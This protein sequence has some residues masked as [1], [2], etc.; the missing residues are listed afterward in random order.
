MPAVV[1][2]NGFVRRSA[3][4]RD[5]R[6]LNESSIGNSACQS[7]LLRYSLT[8]GNTLFASALIAVG[9]LV[10]S[11]DAVTDLRRR[12]GAVA[13]VALRFPSCTHGDSKDRL[14]G[15]GF[16]SSVPIDNNATV[17]GREHNRRVEFVVHFIIL[18]TGSPQ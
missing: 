2:P 13:E 3:R 7:G 14:V 16:G 9:L 15:K 10:E 1:E 8:Q 4:L 18:N 5:G 17:D 6:L 11:A 12:W